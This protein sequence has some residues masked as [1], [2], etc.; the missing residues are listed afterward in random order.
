MI[1]SHLE[2]HN[3][4][5]FLQVNVALGERVFILGPNASGKSNLLDVFRFLHDIAKNGGG[6]QKALYDRGGVSKIRCLSARQQPNVEI[7]VEISDPGGK[8]KKWRYEIGL[9]QEVRGSLFNGQRQQ[10]LVYERVYQNGEIILSRP[11]PDDINDPLRLTQTHLEQINANKKFRNIVNCFSSVLYLHLVPQL[12]KHPSAFTGPGIPEDPYGR[13]FLERVS[14]T[15]IK[16]R[17]ARLRK[18]EEALRIA[19]PQ[20]KALKYQ[21]DET[22]MPHLEATYEH[23]RAKGAKQ[24]EDQFSDGTLRL[25]GLLWSLLEGESL[26]L[27]EEPELSLNA[28]IISQL[29]AL[30]FKLLSSR[31]RQIIL[32][33]HSEA[34]VEDKGIGPG[35]V[36]L[37]TPQTEGTKV[38]SVSDNE[39]IM[40]LINAGFNISSAVMP[41]TRPKRIAQLSL[42]Q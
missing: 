30:M 32:S 35:E 22:G 3:W 10:S 25:I 1:I 17:S 41:Y 7:K 34:L 13:N 21:Q 6:L 8:E 16:T 27:M 24:R 23:W 26:L 11:D 33:T 28:A 9:K 29:P 15:P 38:E 31:E 40:N 5:N 36:L 12:L 14:K 18:I 37:L 20:L 42:F 39:K 19:V 2:L 4:K